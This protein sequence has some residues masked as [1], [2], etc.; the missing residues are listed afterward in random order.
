LCTITLLEASFLENLSR[1]FGVTNGGGLFLLLRVSNHF[2]GVF[3]YFILFYF[4]LF[5]LFWP[6]AS[7]MSRLALHIILLQRLNVIDII[8]I[9]IYFLYRKRLNKRDEHLVDAM[10]AET[11]SHLKEIDLAE[12]FGVGRVIFSTDCLGLQQTIISSSQDR[13]PRGILLREAKYLLS[14]GFSEYQVICKPRYC[15]KPAHQWR[16]H[17]GSVWSID[18]GGFWQILCIQV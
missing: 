2:D 7:L 14:L 6:C 10:H 17:V 8:V 5:S 12:Q 15:N 9:L 4:I 3:F 11:I 16:S 13:A 1:S 18:H